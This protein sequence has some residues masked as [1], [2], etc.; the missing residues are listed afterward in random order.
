[1]FLLRVL[2]ARLFSGSSRVKKGT[3]RYSAPSVRSRVQ[4]SVSYC[5]SPAPPPPPI[6]STSNHMR[7]VTILQYAPRLRSR[8]LGDVVY[9]YIAYKF[10]LLRIQDNVTLI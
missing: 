4:E 8:S 6:A 10:T 5:N 2:R 3:P 1:M 9:S 7:R